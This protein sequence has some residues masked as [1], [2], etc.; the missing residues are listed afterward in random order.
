[1]LLANLLSLCTEWQSCFKW[2]EHDPVG[3]L[4]TRLC[5]PTTP[6][7]VM[8]KCT[9]VGQSVQVQ[10]PRCPTD[11]CHSR[12]NAY[13]EQLEVKLNHREDLQSQTKR[14][15]LLGCFRL[16]WM[17]T[18]GRQIWSSKTWATGSLL[19]WLLQLSPGHLL[20]K[21]LQHTNKYEV[22]VS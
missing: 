22:F 21:R 8:Y 2:A 14:L 1:M 4:S 6:P 16:K 9:N 5:F 15:C 20:I 13:N 3:H 12:D 7:F 18:A 17:Q 19:T 10:I 11:T